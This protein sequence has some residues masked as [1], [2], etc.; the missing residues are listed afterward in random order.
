M[1][2]QKGF[3]LPELLILVWV[4]FVIGAI[5]FGGYVAWHFIAKFW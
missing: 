5:C 2:K 4:T 1:K 3:T